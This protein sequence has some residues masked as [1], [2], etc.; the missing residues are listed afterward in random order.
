VD[1]AALRAIGRHVG[2][3]YSRATDLFEIMRPD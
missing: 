3:A 2:N 1:Q